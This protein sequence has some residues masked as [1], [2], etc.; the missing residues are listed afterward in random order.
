MKNINKL[1]EAI[2][3]KK[4]TPS[5]N[6][7]YA[8]EAGD[9]GEYYLRDKLIY[10]RYPMYFLHDV[11]LTTNDGK[12]AQIDFIAVTRCIIFV[13]ECKNFGFNVK[14]DGEGQFINTSE[15]KSF[16]S[17]LEQNREHIDVLTRIFPE[18]ADRFFPIIVFSN[19]SR[20][21]DRSD[22]SDE[23]KNHIVKVDE[24]I[25][26]MER[27]NEENKRTGFLFRKGLDELSDDKMKRCADD[28]LAHH[29]EK[30]MPAKKKT[31]PKNTNGGYI[32][33]NCKKE[34][35][36]GQYGFHCTACKMILN[37][38]YGHEL[39]EKQIVWLLTNPGK[40]LNMNIGGTERVVYAEAV[41]NNGYIQWKTINKPA[42]TEK[43]TV[44]EAPKKT[45]N[46]YICP[47]CKKEVRKGQNG[48]YCTAKCGM[49]LNKIYGTDITEEQV[50]NLL[51]GN[52]VKINTR[53]GQKTLA[54]TAVK[55]ESNGRTFI[56]WSVK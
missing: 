27:I 16:K 34:V 3:I 42:P 12:S 40:S 33:P 9:A 23:L 21:L 10:S 4:K 30:T 28:F 39:S 54:P 38:I 1:N 51:S 44:S 14:V 47:N 46:G 18:Y 50:K 35:V 5:V 17:P 8:T 56:Q 7:D 2:Q 15:N 52:E 55:K 29:K 45:N 25:P 13:I 11:N 43:K 48:F 32:C 49:I 6:P 37:K 31:A 53:Y 20:I 41:T 36:K 22:T 26:A 24:L 19:T